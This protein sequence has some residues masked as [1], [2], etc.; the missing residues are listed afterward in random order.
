MTTRQPWTDTER[1][2]LRALYPEYTAAECA[3]AMGRTTRSIIN[4]V[5]QLGLH[6]S[7]EWIAQRSREIAQNPNHAARAHRFQPGLVPWN[8]GQPFQ[9]GGRS[10][11]TQFK[12]GR[13]AHEASNW[14]PIG[15]LR[16]CADGY[17]E[18][19]T[20][21]DPGLV[22]ARRW[23]AVHRLVWEAAH[24]P[25]QPGMIV[26]FRPGMRTTSDAEIT[27]ERLELITRAENMKRNTI[28]NYPMPIKSL[29][30]AVGRAQRALENRSE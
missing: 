5:K 22:P 30:R 24:G 16:I 21:D 7:S 11:E 18:R 2:V 8:K 29:I 28:H 17:L 1:A 6:K 20:T 15:S 10:A 19:K 4:Q 27:L 14:L 12:A 23:V 9:S 26:V 3:Q 13:P 25:I